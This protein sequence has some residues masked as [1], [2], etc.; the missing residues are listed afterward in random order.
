MKD[1]T[2]LDKQAGDQLRPLPLFNPP[3]MTYIRSPRIA[4]P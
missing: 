2:R 4:V 1:F 3:S